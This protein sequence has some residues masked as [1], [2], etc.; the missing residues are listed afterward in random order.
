MNQIT[1][2]IKSKIRNL[3]EDETETTELVTMATSV[4][5]GE[6]IKI[7]YPETD[8]NGLGKCTVTLYIVRKKLVTIMRSE[9]VNTYMT[10]EEGESHYSNYNCVLGD[11]SLCVHGHKINFEGDAHTGKLEL[12]YTLELE[13]K[14]LS[15]NQMEISWMP[16]AD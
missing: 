4:Q 7:S 9:P 1:L 2:T 8:L 14:Q 13:A 11:I 16:L 10:M 6:K 3:D 12:E 5:K 15:E